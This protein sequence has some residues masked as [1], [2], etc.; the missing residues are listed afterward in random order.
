M[1]DPVPIHEA[2]A[3]CAARDR[4]VGPCGYAD[5]CLRAA[6]TN[7]AWMTFESYPEVA[8]IDG[9]NRFGRALTSGV[10]QP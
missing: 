9:L 2:P 7:F 10:R 6:P 4:A 5:A 8:R 1:H 3:A